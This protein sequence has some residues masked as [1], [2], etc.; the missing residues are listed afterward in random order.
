MVVRD[1]VKKPWLGKSRNSRKRKKY[2]QIGER[3]PPQSNLL[4]TLTNLTRQQTI[5][6]YHT[7]SKQLASVDKDPTFPTEVT[8]EARRSVLRAQLQVI[9]LERY[10]RASRAGEVAGGGFDS[11]KWVLQILSTHEEA[12]KLHEKNGRIRLLDVGAIVHRFDEH[13]VNSQ[14]VSIPLDVT[15]IDLHPSENADGDKPSVLQA[16]LIDFATDLVHRENAC[17][18]VV[19]LALCVNFEG[20]PRRR[21]LMLYYAARLLRPAGL[22]FL[23]LPRACL[24]NSRYFDG[25]LLRDILNAVG[26]ECVEADTSQALVKWVLRRTDTSIEGGD[27]SAWKPLGK[28]NVVRTGDEHNNF[29]ILLDVG[30]LRNHGSNLPEPCH[31]HEKE[32]VIDEVPRK[33]DRRQWKPKPKRP[34]NPLHGVD[35]KQRTSNQRK[36]AR[37]KAMQGRIKKAAD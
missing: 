22:V 28:K 20:C 34:K 35:S 18:D 25:N 10:Q 32:E 33:Q 4:P 31:Q 7:I 16:D 2:D 8:R 12:A 36:R 15:S 37:K 29:T 19:S 14:N 11:S 5:T 3:P 9:G 21:G 13:M 17:M 23:V 1:V 24:D 27:E 6:Q 30:L 26:L